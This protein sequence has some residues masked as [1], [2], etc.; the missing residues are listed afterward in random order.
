MIRPP[1][2]FLVPESTDLFKD[3]DPIYTPDVTITS[4][5][6]VVDDIDIPVEIKADRPILVEVNDDEQLNPLRPI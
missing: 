2:N 3:Q 1:T 4:L 6:I 5:E